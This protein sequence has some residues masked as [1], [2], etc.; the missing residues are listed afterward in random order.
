TN[1]SIGNHAVLLGKVSV[2]VDAFMDDLKFLNISDRVTGM[3][4][5]EFGRRVKSNSSVGTDHGAAAPLFIFG[6]NVVPGILGTNPVI[7][8]NVN[9][10]DNIPMQYDFRSIYGSILEEWFCVNSTDVSTVLL[11]NYQSLPL[12]NPGA[13]A[14]ASTHNLNSKAGVSLITNY[15]NPFKSITTINFETAGGHTLI[16]IFDTM[17]RLVKTL[18]DEEYP[19]GQYSIPFES[20]NI[21][22]GTYYAR[23]QNGVLQQVRTIMKVQ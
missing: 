18:V 9:V 19:S 6:D 17:G 11:K 12:V 23:L 1:T 20:E 3:T 14:P 7:P 5:S 4:F 8:T 22:A 15:P 2:A 13:C 10:N 16:Q 21:P